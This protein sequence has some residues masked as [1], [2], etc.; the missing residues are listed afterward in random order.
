MPMTS[1][2][3]IKLLKDNGFTYIPSGDGSHKKFKNFKIGRTTIVPDYP[4]KELG[5]VLEHEI[6][7]QAGLNMNCLMKEGI[8]MFVVYPAIFLK[9]F[10]GGYTV[11][12]PDLDGC[13][14][15]GKNLY[16]AFEMAEDAICSYLFE[17]YIDKIAFPP[18]SDISN[19]EI[20]LDEEEKLIFDLSG[21]FISY[22][23]ANVG[24]FI[25]RSENKAVKKTLSIPSYLNEIGISKGVNFSQILQ[26]AL[27]NEFNLS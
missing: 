10:D 19:I 12:V 3:K 9:G 15:E 6:L 20:K 1:R 22:V 14:T 5:K 7:K 26:D 13:L 25:K 21:S 8:V 24:E 2:Q 17:Y 11:N 16:E 18:A 23:H 27:K 4:G